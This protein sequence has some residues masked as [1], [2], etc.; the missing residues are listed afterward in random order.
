[1][2]E[3]LWKAQVKIGG[4][5]VVNTFFCLPPLPKKTMNFPSLFKATVFKFYLFKD[6]EAMGERNHSF[7]FACTVFH[8]GVVCINK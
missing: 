2:F 4:F 1:V 6:S 3:P 5:L 7:I 8:K